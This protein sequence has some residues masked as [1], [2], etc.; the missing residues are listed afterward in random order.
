MAKILPLVILVIFKNKLRPQSLKLTDTVSARLRVGL[1]FFFSFFF[2][3]H[4]WAFY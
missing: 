2:E 3:E 4:K 1:L